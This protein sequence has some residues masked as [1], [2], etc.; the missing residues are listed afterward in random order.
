MYESDV[1]IKL[2]LRNSANNMVVLFSG[3][4]ILRSLAREMVLLGDQSD[5]LAP[6]LV[7]EYRHRNIHG[8]PK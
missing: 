6:V 2:Y 4:E 5:I 1:S 7:A 3:V 8:K